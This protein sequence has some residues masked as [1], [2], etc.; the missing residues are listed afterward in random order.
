[1]CIAG[2]KHLGNF[3]ID[4]RHRQGPSGT[5]KNARVEPGY[6]THGRHTGLPW[7]L[8]HGRKKAPGSGRAEQMHE[9]K[10]SGMSHST[11]GSFEGW[12]SLIEPLRRQDG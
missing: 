5:F 6:L 3:L 12:T 4:F 10:V 2:A 7:S 8:L 11:N 9:V 1:V